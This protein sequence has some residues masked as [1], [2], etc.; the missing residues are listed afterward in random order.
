MPEPTRTFYRVP[1][2]SRATS[3]AVV[4]RVITA[5]KRSEWVDAMA[6]EKRPVIFLSPI[7]GSDDAAAFVSAGAADF[8][9]AAGIIVDDSPINVSDLPNGLSL[10]IG[11]M[12]DVSAYA[13]R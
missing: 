9:R 3:A 10:L 1:R 13:D 12:V 2:E 5:S 8:L 4:G 11:E 7:L 6:S